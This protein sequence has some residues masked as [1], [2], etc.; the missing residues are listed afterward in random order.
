MTENKIK[1]DPK[2]D[3]ILK[4]G[5]PLKIPDHLPKLED[6]WDISLAVHNA[7]E[8]Y[9][10]M[11]QKK[12]EGKDT[13]N[14]Y[15][16]INKKLTD[17]KISS[18]LIQS[19]GMAVIKDNEDKE[20]LTPELVRD[21]TDL[22]LVEKLGKLFAVKE[23]FKSKEATSFISFKNNSWKNY[24]KEE[25]KGYFTLYIENDVPEDQNIV[26]LLPEFW[27]HLRSR[28]SDGRCEL[29]WNN[30]TNSIP[31]ATDGY[32]LS[33]NKGDNCGKIIATPEDDWTYMK[34]PIEKSELESVTGYENW[35][36][37]LDKWFPGDI[38]MQKCIQTMIGQGIA[39][40]DAQL[41]LNMFGDGSNGK[42]V[43]IKALKQALG[44]EYHK[45][46]NSAWFLKE[47]GQRKHEPHSSEISI[48]AHT[49]I[50]VTTETPDKAEIHADRVKMA[51]GQD[52]L[53]TRA[54]Y[55][56]GQ[57]YFTPPGIVIFVGN[58]QPSFK[59]N[60]KSITRRFKLIHFKNSFDDNQQ[61]KISPSELIEYF[62][63][64]RAEILNWI[65]EGI[66]IFYEN[67]SRIHYSKTI[68]DDTN[69]YFENV[70]KL[71]GYLKAILI[72]ID[73]KSKGSKIKEISDKLLTDCAWKISPVN[74]KPELESR[75][76]EIK[77]VSGVNHIVGYEVLSDSDNQNKSVWD[78]PTNPELENRIRKI[79]SANKT[80]IAE[81]EN[82]QTNIDD[83]I[84]T[85]DKENKI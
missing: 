55:G 5:R 68:E 49:K 34:L 15:Q 83:V 3:K 27:N 44:K 6:D 66:Q 38:D 39:G 16:D 2:A 51:S 84:A 70:D 79:Q 18:E 11:A 72:P 50:T 78:E 60:N 41:V 19:I 62:K 33:I 35:Q 12:K 21:K 67:G 65:I 32:S 48:L 61:N 36:K 4:P 58:E 13:Q 45:T 42:S 1:S 52:D 31:L 29:E 73:D 37:E 57:S 28:M 85:I 30:S 40:N 26:S 63:S 76:F 54:M 17:M 59:S 14:F 80:T 23:D 20:R 53:P 24:T 81:L 56:L 9:K 10:W 77:R 75:G 82:K 22:F 69:E 71:G 25:L 43:F 74:L 8:W 46:M 7:Q 47:K 64:I